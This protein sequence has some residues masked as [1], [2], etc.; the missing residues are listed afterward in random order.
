MVLTKLSLLLNAL[1]KVSFVT[2]HPPEN[3]VLNLLIVFFFEE[4]IAK[5]LHGSRDEKFTT[6]QTHVEGTDGPV[7]WKTDR[8]TRQQGVT[9]LPD[10]DSGPIWVDELKPAILIPIR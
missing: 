4:L 3:C 5:K 8:S 1:L 2:K 10:I 7:S 9:W 6:F